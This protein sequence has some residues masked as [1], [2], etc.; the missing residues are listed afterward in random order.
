MRQRKPRTWVMVG[1]NLDKEIDARV[2]IY[3][4]DHNLSINKAVDRLL[5]EALHAIAFPT[6]TKLRFNIQKDQS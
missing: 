1:L 3:A 6:I 4:R 2:R 5:R